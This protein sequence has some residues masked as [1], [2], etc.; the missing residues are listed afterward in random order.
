MYSAIRVT[1]LPGPAF[2]DVPILGIAG[3]HYA[4][5]RDGLFWL[6]VLS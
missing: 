1:V 6:R 2:G 5:P 4:H 3:F